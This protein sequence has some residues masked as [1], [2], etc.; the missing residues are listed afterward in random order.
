MF[1][2]HIPIINQ[3]FCQQNELFTINFMT[4]FISTINILSTINNIFILV[5][6]K[7]PIHELKNLYHFSQ[8]WNKFP[9][10]AKFLDKLGCYWKHKTQHLQAARFFKFL[11]F[12]FKLQSSDWFGPFTPKINDKTLKRKIQFSNDKDLKSELLLYFD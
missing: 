11:K 1:Q 7:L 4:P 5:T 12:V 6:I 10:C 8:I 3:P 2:S 9:I